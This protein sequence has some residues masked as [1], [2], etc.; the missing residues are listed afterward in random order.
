[1]TAG[2]NMDAPER[3]AARRLDHPRMS[4]PRHVNLQLLAYLEAMVS[5]RHITRA[6]ARLGIGQPSMS[7]ALARLRLLFKDPLLVKTR[8]GMEPT[9]YALELARGIRGA[10]EL[11]DVATR[12]SRAFDPAT[13]DDHFRIVS[14]DGV[15]LLFL[16]ALMTE[17]RRAAPSMRFTYS[18]GDI[19]LAGE[20]LRDD[21]AELV[22]A[23]LRDAPPDL[24]Q[25]PLYRQKMVCI[26]SGTHPA[27]RGVLTVEQFRAYPHVVFGAPPVSYTSME[28]MVDAAMAR[29][30]LERQVGLRVPSITLSPAIVAATDMLA[31]VPERVGLEGARAL[32]LQVLPVPFE[33]ERV[34]LSMFW[35]ARWHRDPAHIWLRD[36]LRAVAATLQPARPAA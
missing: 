6:A 36:T 25:A 28:A 32:S 15:A 7:A 19:R 24:H 30:G 10:L 18:T 29:A 14:S 17:A 33:L 16:P 8:A 21:E 34:D 27:I 9:P 13:A 5:E 12:A 3:G 2:M 22:V 26:A 1:M 20:Y 23:N 31:V 4:V 11:I 35:H